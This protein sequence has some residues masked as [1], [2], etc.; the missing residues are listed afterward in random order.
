MRHQNRVDTYA[1]S[2]TYALRAHNSFRRS[3][4]FS[5]IEVLISIVVLSFGL[6]GMV[7]MQAAALQSNREAR[8]QSS[9][10]VLAR[11]LA[12]LMR[13]NK[14]IGILAT[15]NPYLGDFNTPLVAAT[16]SYCLNVAPATPLC[17]NATDIANAQMTEWL[18]RVDAELPGAH[19]KTCFDSAPFDSNGLP[20][21]TCNNTGGVVV[22]KIGWTRGSTDRSKSGTAAFERAI[23]PSVIFSV[24]AGM[25]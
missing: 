24:T 18:A 22:V 12:E 10:V 2:A 19:V 16:P 7:G 3:A 15:G 8:L 4:G 5:L 21:W 17:T 9:A 11:E 1:A 20:I 14:A 23:R 6:L 13:G 25:T